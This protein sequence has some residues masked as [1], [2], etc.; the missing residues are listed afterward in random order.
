MRGV[1]LDRLIS[2]FDI[3]GI[4]T[5]SQYGFRKGRSTE[6]ALLLIKDTILAN[7]KNRKYTLR[8]FLNIKKAFDSIQYDLLLKKLSVYGVRGIALEQ[9]YLHHR[10]QAV[11]IDGI[12]SSK[13]VLKQ[14]VP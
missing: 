10:Y 13:L 5:D 2:F 8:L 7:I 12:M 6:Q 3:H 9:S 4:I 1:I 14:G 11:N